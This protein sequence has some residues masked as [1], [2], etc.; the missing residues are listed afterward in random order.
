[1]KQAWGWLIAGVL[2]LGLNGFYQDG[3]AA[4][5]HRAI[6]RVGNEIGVRSEAALALATGRADWFAAKADMLANRNE[7][8]T[9]HMGTTFARLQTKMIRMQGGMSRFEAISA[10]EEAARARLEAVQA[11][12]GADLARTEGRVFQI[13]FDPSELKKVQCPRIHINV[14]QVSI[15][16]PSI[17]IDP[18]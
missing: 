2:A 16:T 13:N 18:M 5:V 4:C 1:M 15:S 10:R 14:P 11:R 7:T 6:D 9:C 12:R 3:G 8:A 17:R